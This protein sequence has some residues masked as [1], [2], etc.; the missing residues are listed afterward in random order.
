MRLLPFSSGVLFA[1][2]CCS[3]A[4]V[5]VN[6]YDSAGES[7]ND[8]SSS[9]SPPR[10]QHCAEWSGAKCDWEPS[11]KPMNVDFGPALQETFYA[12]VTP[13]VSTFYNRT[14]KSMKP[15]EPNF[16][17]FYAKFINMSPEQVVLY[18]ESGV[19]NDAPVH[20]ADIAPFNSGGTAS[21]HGHKFFLAPKSEPGNVLI[22][23]T[24][25]K[26]NS[27]Y[28][29]DPYGANT[30]EAMKHLEGPSLQ[31]YQMQ[32]QNR[33]FAEQYKKF[34][35]VDWL[36]LYK[37]K[38]PPRYHMWRAD[39]IGQTHT[40]ETREIHFVEQPTQDEITRGMSIYGPRPDEVQRM[41]KHRDYHPTLNLTL[42]AVSCAPRV[43]E[44]PN[45]LSG[46]EI[47]HILDIARQADL[48]RST[49][50]MT[51]AGEIRAE[52]SVRTSRNSWIQ[53]AT[54]FMTD[55]VYKRAAD[56]LQMDEALLRARRK[57]EIPEFYESS[58]SVAEKLQLV[59]YS[60]GQEYAPHHDF[61]MP[62]LV[63]QQPS[64]FATILF[65][66]NDDV[67]GGE[68]SFPVWLNAE[69]S[70]PLKVRLAQSPVFEASSL[71]GIFYL[72][73]SYIVISTALTLYSRS[74][75]S[76][77]RPYFFIIFCQMATTTRVPS[78]DRCR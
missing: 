64:R 45:F 55:T 5:V 18:Y 53:R 59:H 14:E 52:S 56:V 9:P 49:V 22:R 71:V 2:W 33:A 20:M 73:T 37:Q 21:Y 50:S 78:M 15:V 44:I 34:A 12:Y 4:A 6:G 70:E 30:R 66:L 35:G 47:D 24:V 76:E 27:L 29:Y 40:V 42:T 72:C 26:S 60:V 46:V 74:N 31:Y 38:Q 10:S 36:S 68:T 43:F 69:T 16:T 19:P 8:P 58:M 67:E 63:N 32:L 62:G 77:E 28:Y 75:Q 65:Y 41:R 54:D 61:A 39:Y 7:D 25:D 1:C 13:D 23:W 11:L 17:G 3:L 51:A 57:T 48:Q